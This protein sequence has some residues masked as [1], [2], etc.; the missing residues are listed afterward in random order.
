MCW[1]LND[2]GDLITLKAFKLAVNALF[3]NVENWTKIFSNRV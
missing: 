2:V 1:L 3:E